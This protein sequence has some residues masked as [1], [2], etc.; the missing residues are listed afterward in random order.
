M[1]CQNL[2]NKWCGAIKK[3][4]DFGNPDARGLAV[5]MVVDIKTYARG[6]GLRL[7]L[8]AD[9]R[10]ELGGKFVWLGF[11]PFCGA[12]VSKRTNKKARS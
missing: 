2:K 11:C 1:K 12:D 4:A 7:G 5:S 10:K 9:K 6:Y 3:V 8:S